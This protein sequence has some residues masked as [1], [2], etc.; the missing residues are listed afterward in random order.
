MSR[1]I[2]WM[3]ADWLRRCPP[4]GAARAMMFRTAG[5]APFL[6]A[7][8]RKRT[9]YGPRMF[10]ARRLI[11]NTPVGAGEPGVEA[12]VL[13]GAEGVRLVEPAVVREAPVGKAARLVPGRAEPAGPAER[14]AARPAIRAGP[15]GEGQRRP[16]TIPTTT[17]S[18]IPTISRAPSFLN[19]R[20]RSQPIS[21]FL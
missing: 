1:S 11:P 2:R 12:V 7:G 10:W 5:F 21:R 4:A 18:T 8:Q 3:C 17:T 14:V 15:A 9:C 20:L 6:I 16:T 19:C 13:A